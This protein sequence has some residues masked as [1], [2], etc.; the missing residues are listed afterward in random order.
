MSCNQEISRHN[1]PNSEPQR[2]AVRGI[3][4]RQLMVGFLLTPLL[5]GGCATLPANIKRPESHALKDTRDTTLGRAVAEGQRAHPGQTGFHLLANGRDAFVARAVLAQKAERS[6]DVQYYLYHNDLVGRLFSHVL[7]MAADRGV[8][9]RL[10]VDDMDM[11]D[12]DFGATVMEL[13]PNI[14]VRLFNP[15]GR[16]TSR[17]SQFITR[18]GSVTRR[19]HNKSFV[20][21]SQMAILGGRNIGN[22]YFEA[23][24]G[25]AF[26]DLDV[27]AG[28]PVAGE[29]SAVF[30][31]FWNHA[32]AYP[33]SAL[34]MGEA[35]TDETMKKFRQSLGQFVAEQRDSVYLQA[36]RDSDLAV[37]IR[38]NQLAFE[39]GDGE[40]VFD[41]PE[42]LIQDVDATEFHLGPKLI[43]YW[44]GVR[45]EL[46]IFSPYFVPGDKGTEVLAGLVKRGVRVRILTNSLS[47]NDV[48]LVHAGYK[49]YRKELLRNG[50]E[51]YEMNKKLATR[52]REEKKGTGG[53][54][55]ASLHAKSFVFD[56]S[57]VF[58]G[59]LNLDPRAVVFNTEIGVV[60]KVL[61]IS[62]AMSKWFEQ[63]I[64]RVAFRLE[65]KKDENGW[66]QLLWHG[67]ENEEPVMFTHE[68]Y[69]GFWQRAKIEFLSWW[70]IQ[71]Q[72]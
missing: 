32:L 62:E 58:I 12:R 19:M 1:S 33:A 18:M 59:S 60:L 11:A 13:H 8:R 7:L 49:K 69:A 64:E 51:L 47:S 34:Y 66:E 53:S 56:R 6:L 46:L 38:N 40:V 14:E 63:N 10:L 23:D 27:I 44:N 65:L 21:D 70:P 2:R 43:P 15:F 9:V 50:V 20:V 57:Q 31:L 55:K 36:L 45:K 22:E 26:A 71:S 25:L 41:H 16:N 61:T 28:G 68:P 48:E 67:W 42:K 39:W 37:K 24:P 29:V 35:V 54:S 72:L 5:T 3:V 52:Q 30:D 17:W 4:G